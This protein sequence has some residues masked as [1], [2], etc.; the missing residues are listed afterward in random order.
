MF[1][2]FQYITFREGLQDI[3]Y[4]IHGGERFVKKCVIIFT[5]NEEVRIKTFVIFALKNYTEIEFCGTI[6]LAFFGGFSVIKRT[7]GVGYE[8]Q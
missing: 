6:Y 8:K 2:K 7:G 5:K 1:C 3:L 4:P